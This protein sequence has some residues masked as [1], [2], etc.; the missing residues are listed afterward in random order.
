MMTILFLGTCILLGWCTARIVDLQE[1]VAILEEE[2]KH[3][4]GT[5]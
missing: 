3:K 5:E 2:I 4:L 1:R